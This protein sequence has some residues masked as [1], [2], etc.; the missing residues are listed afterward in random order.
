MD[1]FLKK[2]SEEEL[3]RITGGGGPGDGK[4]HLIVVLASA[5]ESA[6]EGIMTAIMKL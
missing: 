1:K 3:K 5:P 6:K 2:A 4:A